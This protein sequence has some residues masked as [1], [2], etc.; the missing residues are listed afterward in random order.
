M[1]DSTQPS[2][3]TPL[4]AHTASPP[5]LLL[6][7]GAEGLNCQNGAVTPAPASQRLLGH[8]LKG[9]PSGFPCIL[10]HTGTEYPNASSGDPAPQR[11]LPPACFWGPRSTQTTQAQ[12]QISA[13]HTHIATTSLGSSLC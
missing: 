8:P 12:A 4:N 11:T 7:E 1:E 2:H 13:S 3:H 9:F 6:A 10:S 5:C